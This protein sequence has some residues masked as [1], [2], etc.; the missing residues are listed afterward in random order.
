LEECLPGSEY[1]D[2]LPDEQTE[3]AVAPRLIDFLD[4]VSQSN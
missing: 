2:V 3:S 1:W 4:R